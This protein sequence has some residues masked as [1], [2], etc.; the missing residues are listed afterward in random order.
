MSICLMVVAGILS[1]HIKKVGKDEKTELTNSNL[2]AWERKLEEHDN[3]FS[4]L[5]IRGKNVE[6]KVLKAPEAFQDK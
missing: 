4:I 2:P 3:L 6:V 5:W 1:V